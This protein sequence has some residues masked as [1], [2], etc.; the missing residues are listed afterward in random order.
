MIKTQLRLTV[1][2]F[3]N[4]VESFLAE[5]HLRTTIGEFDGDDR[6]GKVY[7]HGILHG[8]LCKIVQHQL[9]GFMR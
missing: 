5:Q 4:P 6:I 8:Q 2:P 7:E 3:L 1:D 9:G